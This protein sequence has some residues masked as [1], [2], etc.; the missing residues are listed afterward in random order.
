[1]LAIRLT[2]FSDFCQLINAAV[3]GPLTP[4]ES[5]LTRLFTGTASYTICGVKSRA[6]LLMNR[7]RNEEFLRGIKGATRIPSL[8]FQSLRRP[9]CAAK[10]LC[11]LNAGE[12]ESHRLHQKNSFGIRIFCGF[13]C[14][15]TCVIAVRFI[16]LGI[17]VHEEV[18]CPCVECC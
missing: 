8:S 11:F 7:W 13:T 18:L 3:I 12:F 1:V 6:A 14:K 17:V 9:G 16:E 2:N 10:L 15:L 5:G 4:Q